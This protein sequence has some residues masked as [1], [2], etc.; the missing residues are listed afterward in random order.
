MRITRREV[1]IFSM[2][3]LDLF[4]SALGAF[5]L[6]AVV[7]LPF[8]GNTSRIP[9]SGPLICPEPVVCPIPEPCEICA[10]PGFQKIPK[11]DLVIVLDISGSMQ[12]VLD[13]MKADAGDVVRLLDKLSDSAA[14]RLVVFGDD[15]FS[16]PVTHF[17]ITPTSKS[18]QLL[19]QI[20]S[21][22]IDIGIGSG[23]N[24]E[25]GEAVYAGV[26][27]A[28]R[29]PF[30]A[31][32]LSVILILTDDEPH[33]YDRS[34]LDSAARGFASLGEKKLSVYYVGADSGDGAYYRALATSA[35]GQYFD[36]DS[37]SSVTAALLLALLP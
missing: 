16:S 11:V 31:D 27:E 12:G 1:N 28:L 29:T 23:S 9:A 14:V 7:A 22:H 30:R 5:I 13:R 37:A 4:A 21:V 24:G 36:S 34:M 33:P 8:F 19:S 32:A 6:L 17:P 35:S 2:S 15:Q 18:A 3:A 20:G 26:A 10:P 25:T